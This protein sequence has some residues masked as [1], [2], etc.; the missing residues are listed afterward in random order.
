MQAR[1]TIQ[2]EGNKMKFYLVKHRF[3]N[4]PHEDMLRYDDAKI[5]K[6]HD[7]GWYEIEGVLM[8]IARWESFGFMVREVDDP[9]NPAKNELKSNVFAFESQEVISQLAA[10][11][12]K[13]LVKRHPSDYPKTR[14][15]LTK[16]DEK[17]RT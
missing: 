14:E 2:E 11:L 15:F 12:H 17:V 5:V 6:K 9:A 16:L 1:I 13:L 10:E 4:A 3:G 7:T 8:T